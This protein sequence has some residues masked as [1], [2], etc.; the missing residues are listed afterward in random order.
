MKK[1][2]NTL[3][4]L[5]YSYDIKIIESK[6]LIKPYCEII[7]NTFFIYVPINKKF[8]KLQIITKW[9]IE[10]AKRIIPE[11]IKYYLEKFNFNFNFKTNRIFY[12]NQKT[13]WGSCSFVNN[14]NFNYNI[15]NKSIEVIDYLVVHELSHTIVK[16]HSKQFWHTVE[17]ILP[18]YKE[19]K[20]ELNTN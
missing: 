16:N 20:K 6:L 19:L 10:Q 4:F 8:D 12:K 9:K 15:V 18:N 2:N 3:F 11:R 7:N 17:N 1:E 13:R 14:L 5:G